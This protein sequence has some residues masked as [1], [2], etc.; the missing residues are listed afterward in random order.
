MK[1]VPWKL[2]EHVHSGTKALNK[3]PSMNKQYW[4]ANMHANIDAYFIGTVLLRIAVLNHA[5]KISG[6]ES[7]IS[8]QHTS[9]A[10][11]ASTT[12][13]FE[14]AMQLQLAYQYQH[15]LTRPSLPFVYS[16]E[17]SPRLSVICSVETRKTNSDH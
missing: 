3:Y 12:T 17:Q 5:E 1:G 4:R 9:N 13:N 7:C 8:I 6:P 15:K 11:L 2:V 14:K 16:D 10:T